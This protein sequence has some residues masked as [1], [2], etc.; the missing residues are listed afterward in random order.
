MRWYD[1]MGDRPCADVDLLVAPHDL[2]RVGELVELL[3][4]DHR[5]DAWA[6][7]RLV[8]EGAI[9]SL[10]FRIDGVAIDVHFDLF[11]L[12]YP[13]RQP[14]V[15][16]SRT[17]PVTLSEGVR[18]RMLDPEL[19]FVHFLL[20]LNRDK[21][22]SLLG[23]TDI[24][25]ILDREVLD[26]DFIDRFVRSEGLETQHSLTLEAVV[27]TLGLPR[28]D[29]ASATGWR[30]G[31]WRIAW[32]P[33]TRLLG[34]VAA[35]RFMRRG[36]LLLPLLVHGRGRAAVLYWMRRLFP[37]AAVIDIKHPG[38]N[39][40]YLWRLITGRIGQTGERAVDRLAAHKTVARK[41]GAKT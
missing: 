19:S 41:N 13:G 23:Y 2:H 38:T 27:D 34:D 7:R 40:P 21:F 20:H 28:A 25:R 26:W 33:K 9:Q 5:L 14:E 4:P 1:G 10:D 32:R 18:T 6:V 16:W 30:A 29:R 8:A 15:V 22:R 36:P 12:G 17:L 31:I 39:G 35:I 11:K 3:E 37:P 24:A